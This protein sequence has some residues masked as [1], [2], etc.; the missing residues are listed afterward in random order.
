MASV[1]FLKIF[2]PMVFSIK[3][4]VLIGVFGLPGISPV[5]AVP[6]EATC[7]GPYACKVELSGA[8]I[9][10]SNGL[11]I[12]TDNVIGWSLVN[13]TQ[14]GNGVIFKPR[15]E[16]YRFLIKYFDVNGDRRITQIGFYNFTSAQSFTSSLELLTGL[17][18]N[19]DQSGPTTKCTYAGKN[20]YSGTILADP[21]IRTNPLEKL[22][23]VGIGAA[24]GAGIGSL[25]DGTAQLSSIAATP[26]GAIIGGT[27]LY[28]LQHESGNF[29]LS[30][31]VMSDTRSRPVAGSTFYDASFDKNDDCKDQP[32]MTPIPLRVT[33]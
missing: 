7:D 2:S 25:M 22:L 18:P 31:N 28:A 3:H 16:D 23:G 20:I 12:S 19:H 9:S 11:V 17:A 8:A 5:N 4:L 6:L 10:T 26:T 15:H 24:I 14:R 27:A 29:M 33:N 32:I 21:A 13:A 30:K 1:I